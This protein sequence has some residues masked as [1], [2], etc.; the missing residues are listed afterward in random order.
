[1]H[2]LRMQAEALELQTTKVK[3]LKEGLQQ[4]PGTEQER[5]QSQLAQESSSL[6]SMQARRALPLFLQPKEPACMMVTGRQ[7]TIYLMLAWWRC[8]YRTS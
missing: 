6:S 1:M 4:R 3:A 8:A 5:L 7:L 2:V